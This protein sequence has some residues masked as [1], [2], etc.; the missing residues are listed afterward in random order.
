M[1]L[2]LL[3]FDVGGTEIKYGIVK[4]ALTITDKGFVPSPKDSFDSFANM[5][6]SIYQQYKDKVDGIA[7]SLPGFIDVKNGRCN[8]GG[9]LR[10]NNGLFI[11]PLLEEKC[12]CRVVLE[13]DGKAAALAEYRYGAL[14]GC[15]NAA[16]FVIGTGVGG[17]LIINGQIVRG[18][19]STSGEFS[20]LVSDSRE[21]YDYANMLGN[22][23]STTFLLNTYQRRTGSSKPIDGLEFFARMSEDPIAQETLNELCENIA[24]QIYNL[25]WLLDLEKIAIGGGI[26]KQPIVTEKIKEKFKEVVEKSFTGQSHFQVEIEIVPCRFGND[27]NLIGSYINYLENR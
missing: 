11:G 10:Y 27:A 1:G 21:F 24:K 13:N 19:H 14:Q 25:Y 18:R 9:S 8:G 17:G 3:A 6:D 16:V 15:G 12:G 22:N 5:I 20:F 7:M 23:C 4:N 26:S 2:K